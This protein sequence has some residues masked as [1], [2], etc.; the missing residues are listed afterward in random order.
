MLDWWCTMFAADAEDE[1]RWLIRYNFS[2][3]WS[4]CGRY[5]QQGGGRAHRSG[6]VLFA[7]ASTGA[8]ESCEVYELY[9]RC[10]AV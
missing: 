9:S 1:V 7:T 4:R 8:D 5:G 6:L 10:G 3:K 2:G